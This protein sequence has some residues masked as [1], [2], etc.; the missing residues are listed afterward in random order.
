MHIMLTC[1]YNVDP[2]TPHVYIVKLEFAKGIL[3]LFFSNFAL[4]ID[5]GYS[6][7]PPQ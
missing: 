4:N 3:F 1:P 6:L 7:E 5:R 2:L